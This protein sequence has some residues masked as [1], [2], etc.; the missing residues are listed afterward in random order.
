LLAT[1][2]GVALF[3][4]AAAL[5]AVLAVLAVGSHPAVAGRAG[6]WA[7]SVARHVRPGIDPAKVAENS[8]R[9]AALARPR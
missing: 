7:A 6:R 2:A 3:L 1:L 5:A 8:S 9:L 4:V